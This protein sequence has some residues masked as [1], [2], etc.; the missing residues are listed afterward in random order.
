MACNPNRRTL[1][2]AM[3]TTISGAGAAEEARDPDNRRIMTIPTARVGSDASGMARTIASRLWMKVPLG[4]WMPSSLGT[5][6]STMTSRDPRF[7]ADQHRFRNEVGDEAQPQER[8]QQEDSS[9]QESQCCRSSHQVRRIAIRGDLA[10]LGRRQDG[11]RRGGAHA[12]RPRRPD[13]CVDRHRHQRRVEPYLQPA[14]RR[15]WR[16]PSPSE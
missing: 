7:E 12:E 10:E 14:A 5:W 15:S 6:S 11:Q 13:H 9:H 3:A 1:A 4:K 16:R 2:I 8:S